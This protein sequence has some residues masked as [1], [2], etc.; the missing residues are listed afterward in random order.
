MIVPFPFARDVGQFVH[1]RICCSEG[2]FFLNDQ[3][4][5]LN[6]FEL[7]ETY[8]REPLIT[9]QFTVLLRESVTPQADHIQ[10]PW[11]HASINRTEAESMLRRVKQEGAFLVP[12]PIGLPHFRLY[13]VVSLHR[14]VLP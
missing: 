14:C 1:C 11:F 2:K 5:F 6:L 9:A 10:K 8:R 3:Y 13:D 7:I 12:P 4:S